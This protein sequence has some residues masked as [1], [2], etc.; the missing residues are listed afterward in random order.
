M[1]DYCAACGHPDLFHGDRAIAAC[2]GG[3]GL[4]AQGFLHMPG[5]NWYR[6]VGEYGPGP[7][8]GCPGWT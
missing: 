7:E 8:C 5:G 1:T 6:R 2:D 4:N 3:Y